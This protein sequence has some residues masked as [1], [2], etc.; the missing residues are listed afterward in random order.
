MKKD[1]PN[2]DGEKRK[3]PQLNGNQPFKDAVNGNGKT[4][5]T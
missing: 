5:I 2:N 4:A 1:L 3:H